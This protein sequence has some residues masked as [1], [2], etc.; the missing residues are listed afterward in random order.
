M[1]HLK[2]GLKTLLL[3]ILFT[4][5]AALYFVLAKNTTNIATVY[6][7]YV[8][9]VA[10]LTSGY[11]WCVIAS[12]AGMLGVNYLFTYPYFAFNFV[13]VGY[14]ITF[15]GMLIIAIITSTLTAYS[16]EQAKNNALREACLNKLNE[17]NK[18]FIIADSSKQI[19]ELTLN[20]IVS[21][22]NISCVF[23]PSDPVSCD[24]PISIYVNPEDKEIFT[25][26]YEQAIA[27]LA[28]VSG[29]ATG[30]D[31]PS[32]NASQCFYLPIVSRNRIWGI[33][34][35]MA[36]QNPDFI[37]DNLSFFTL[38]VP[39]MAL[40]F[41]KQALADEHHSLAIEAEKEKM[42]SNLLRAI[43]HDLRTPLTGMIGSSSVYIEH[44]AS[45]NEKDKLEL[46]SQINE[47]ANWLLHMVENLL[48]V[49]RIVKDTAKV[50]KNMEL[51]EEV[52]SEAVMRIKK[53]YPDADIHVTIPEEAIMLPMDATLIE[54][55]IINLVEN[56]LKYS[57]SI[58][59]IE[60]E[61]VKDEHFIRISVIDYGIGIAEDKLDILFDG[62]T[63]DSNPI[64]DSSKGIGIG[65]SICKT[66]ITAHGGQ[67]TAKNLYPGAAFSFT[68]P[69]EENNEGDETNVYQN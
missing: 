29:N 52:V 13:I 36:S 56:A 11:I 31:A 69:L 51:L 15:L 62:Y 48:S 34:G 33:L 66:I 24:S 63:P 17:I 42:R 50:I 38:M 26:D 10:R 55:V 58:I 25:S 43:S 54:Q 18:Q 49:T 30:M 32:I 45:I 20:Y 41:D 12:L 9:L 14:P 8:F 37:K 39:Q 22:A 6:V 47:D 23:Y 27:H 67:I 3:L 16:K 53:R 35:F 2:D 1:Q 40:A 28:Y 60:V 46:V 4:G 5:I 44:H 57:Q 7:L 65:L 19:I 21:S 59:P 61:S 68:L 64:S